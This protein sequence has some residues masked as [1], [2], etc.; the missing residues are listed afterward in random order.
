MKEELTMSTELQRLRNEI[1]CKFVEINA[2]SVEVIDEDL[3]FKEWEYN[4][5]NLR[6]RSLGT[7]RSLVNLFD[8]L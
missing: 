8:S 2:S 1:N 5:A 4:K 7:L 3:L 6:N